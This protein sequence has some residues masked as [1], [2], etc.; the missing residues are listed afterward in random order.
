MRLSTERDRD[1]ARAIAVLHAA[2][3]AGINFLDTADAYC[4]D[5]AEAGHNERLIARA[6]STWNGDRSRVVIATKGGLTRPKAQWVADG[7][8]RHL[9]AACEASRNA[10]GVDRISLYQLHAPDPRTPLATSVRA[11]DSLKGDGL[12]DA[13][14]LCNVNVGQI[15][16]ARRISEI[17]TVQVE[18]SIWNDDSLLNGVAEYCVANG[19]LLIAHRPLGGT[20][21]GRRMLTDSSLAAIARRHG[22]TPFEIALAWLRDL[23]NIVVPIAGPTHVDTARSIARAHAIALTNEDRAQLDE[24]F[25][26]GRRLRVRDAPAPVRTDGEVVLIMGLPGAGKSTLANTFVVSGYKRLNR[27]TAGGS[28]AGLLPALDGLVASGSSRIVLDNTYASRR[29][30][31]AVIEAARKHRLPVRCVWLATSLEDSQVNA[32][33]RIV[34]RYERVLDPDEMRQA[35]KRD[36]AAFAPAVLFRYQRELEPP[37]LSEGFSR[38][39]MPPFMR[40]H[41][42]SFDTRA[43]ILWCDGILWQSRSG[44]RTPGAPDDVEVVAKRQEVI[45]RCH[46]EG[47]RLLGLSW[48]PEIAEGTRTREQADGAIARLQTLLG[49]PF[50]IEYCPHGGGPAMCWCRKPLPGLGVVFIQRHRLDPS[51]CIYVGVGP[52]DPAFAR[53]LGFQYRDAADFFVTGP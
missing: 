5:W 19:I 33:Q 53:R 37:D 12:I 26:M 24:R 35:R 42:I 51:K 23:S 6:L 28:L 32:V 2:L 36:V 43:L 41:D 49:L 10:L 11:L 3:D 27:D 8:S 9:L 45:R 48:Q 47:W 29:S 16:E 34:S 17:A 21:R 39:E 1:P 20:K 52:Q 44:R 46:T 25:P 38:I 7:R 30:R 18:L 13:I 50:E 15:E 14:G 31:A 22:A 40:T 4:W